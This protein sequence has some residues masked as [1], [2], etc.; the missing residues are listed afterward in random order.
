M[1]E[2]AHSVPQEGADHLASATVSNDADKPFLRTFLFALLGAASFIA[3]VNFVIDPTDVFHVGL[4]PPVT[5]VDRDEKSV[6][7]MQ[8]EAK[9]Q[10]LIIGSSRMMKMNPAC[11]SSLTGLRAF[12]FAVND[13]R[14]EDYLAILRFVSDHGGAPRR[15]LIGVDP[16]GLS[17]EPI[18]WRLANSKYLSR[19]LVNRPSRFTH[20]GEN[21]LSRRQLSAS[22]ASVRHVLTHQ[23]ST[24]RVAPDGF[25]TYLDLEPS[26]ARGDYDL[27]KQLQVSVTGYAA[28]F[29]HFDAL[30]PSRVKMLREFFVE[31]RRRAIV[32]D[33]VI[34]P[35]HPDLL[36]A[37]ARSPLPQRIDDT[38]RLLRQ[39]EREG[40]IHYSDVTTLSGFGGD[41]S[42][43]FD[44]IHMEEWNSSRVLEHV[45]G[46]RCAVQ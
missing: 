27:P 37:M 42:R 34:P 33:A 15:I 7:F 13:A 28:T 24:I 3:A 6:F 11:A 38:E 1:S 16:E 2:I 31:C 39:L 9:P 35:L 23:A 4:L 32:V 44:G 46:G 14:A 41:P 20:L 40:L 5:W 30:S 43:F 8:Q 19:Y 22:I 29:E 36:A 12:N 17:H 10:L 21:L 26:K 18:D 25:L 45:Y